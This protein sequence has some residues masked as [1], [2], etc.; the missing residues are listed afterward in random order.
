MKI[1][2]LIT[3]AF[4]GTILITTS[5]IVNAGQVFRFQD[6]NGVI[7]M[8]KTLPPYAAQKGYDILDDTTMRVIEAVAPALTKAEITEYNRQQAAH[9]EQQQLAVTEAKKQ[10]ERHRQAMLY[11]N[12]LRAR[13]RSEEDLLEKRETELLYFQNQIDKTNADLTRNNDKLHQFQQQAANIELNGRSIDG[14]LKKRLIATEQ[15]INNNKRELTRLTAENKASIIQ[16][17]QDL[18]RLKQLLGTDTKQHI[19]AQ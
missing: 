13:Y 2:Q 5:L 7:T 11:D 16:F 1:S 6:K 3:H 18:L 19:T 15:E 4:L 17:D 12:N 14:N 8:S 10:A 9:K